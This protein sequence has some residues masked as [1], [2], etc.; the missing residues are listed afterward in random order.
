MMSLLLTRKH[1]RSK[2]AIFGSMRKN[3]EVSGC[4]KDSVVHFDIDEQGNR[5]EQYL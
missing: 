2:V 4:G 1:L 3:R 5:E